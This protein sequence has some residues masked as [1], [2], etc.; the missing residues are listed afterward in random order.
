MIVNIVDECT[1]ELS[2]FRCRTL[3]Q[4]MIHEVGDLDGLAT[5]FGTNLQS[6]SSFVQWL[7]CLP[8]G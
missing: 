6:A 8:T 2:L 1:I 7:V 4:C 5:Y 3:S